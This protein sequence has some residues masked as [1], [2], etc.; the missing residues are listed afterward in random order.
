MGFFVIVNLV[1]V[2][3]FEKNEVLCFHLVVDKN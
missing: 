2:F 1:C 3:L